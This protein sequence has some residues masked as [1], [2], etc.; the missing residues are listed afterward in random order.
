MISCLVR[1]SNKLMRRRAGCEV[2]VSRRTAAIAGV[3]RSAR[4][5]LV[6]ARPSQQPTRN[7]CFA[8]IHPI[9]RH[10][11]VPSTIVKSSTTAVRFIHHHH[12]Q[13]PA[14]KVCPDAK[15]ALALSGLKSGDM[16]AVGG[17]G[18]GGI[19]ETLLNELSF[20]DHGPTSLTVVSL[21]AGVDSFGLGRLF[22]AGK[23]KRMISSYVGENKVGGLIVGFVVNL[24]VNTSTDL[25]MAKCIRT[26]IV[27][28]TELRTHVFQWRARGRAGA[29][30]NNSCKTSC[31]WEWNAGNLHTGWCR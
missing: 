3:A 30:G 1:S 6:F 14:S 26:Q 16:I 13:T 18:L 17:F 5:S 12:E 31:H 27:Q 10:N 9:V 7:C 11:V 21:T 29:A 20:Q 19:P 25:F 23:V 24:C 15:T 28:P 22:E 2:E 4:S 8:V